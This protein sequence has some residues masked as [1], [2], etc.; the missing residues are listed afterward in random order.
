MRRWAATLC[1]A[2]ALGVF[3]APEAR[4][5]K[6]YGAVIL[7]EARKVARLR[8]P[9]IVTVYD[10]G[11]PEG[12]PFLVSD[13]VSGTTLCEMRTCSAPPNH[14]NRKRRVSCGVGC[15]G[16]KYTTFPYRS[17]PYTVSRGVVVSSSRSRHPVVR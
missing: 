7:D 9:G 11:Q 14:Q 4:A 16:D 13:F 3:T 5:D 10:V 6:V 15:A 2:L 12:E 1:F 8:H 17:H